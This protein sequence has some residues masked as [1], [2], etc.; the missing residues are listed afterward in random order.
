MKAKTPGQRKKASRFKN[1]IQKTAAK[2]HAI[3]MAVARSLNLEQQDNDIPATKFS[4][5]S[6][7]IFIPRTHTIM[8][9]SAQNRAAKKKRRAHA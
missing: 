2:V 7:P 1:L 9:Y 8:S 3:K 5:Y 4:S 6:S